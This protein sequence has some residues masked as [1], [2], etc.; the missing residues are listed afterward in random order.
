MLSENP[1]VGTCIIVYC[2]IGRLTWD[3]FLLKIQLLVKRLILLFTC[4]RIYVLYI[5]VPIRN[6]MSCI[7]QVLHFKDL[8]LTIIKFTRICV[9]KYI[10]GENDI[11]FGS[12]FVCVGHIDVHGP[13]SY[14]RSTHLGACREDNIYS[15]KYNSCSLIF[16]NH[17]FFFNSEIRFLQK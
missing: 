9:L 2:K 4:Q 10:L 16:S 7:N 11:G 17:I 3:I 13:V 5:H 15:N 12:I 8:W 6:L 14:T 1:I